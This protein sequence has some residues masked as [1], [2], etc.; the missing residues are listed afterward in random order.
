MT[1]QGNLEKY[2]RLTFIFDLP[3]DYMKII[4]PDGTEDT[5]E[6]FLY[7]PIVI[8]YD[9]EGIEK[10]EKSGTVQQQCRYTPDF[11]GSAKLQAYYNHN[12]I[13]ECDINVAESSN[14]GYIEVSKND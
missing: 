8:S 12:L 9:D 10:A 1:I 14:H 13:E 6:M 4:R 3:I 2:S 5:V 11:C 7:Q